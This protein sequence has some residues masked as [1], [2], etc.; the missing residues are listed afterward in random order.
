MAD[1]TL[2]DFACLAASPLLS[3]RSRIAREGISVSRCGIP[4]NPGVRIGT[5]Q[6]AV[7]VHDSEP[8]E[9]IC[10]S[11]RR[12]RI[13]RHRVSAGHF[14]ISAAGRAAHVSWTAAMCSLVIAMEDR[15]LK[16]T[17]ADAFGGAVPRVRS[18]AALRDPA[19]E[20]LVACLR[21]GMSDRSPSG[22]LCLE[23]VGMSLALRLFETYGDIARRPAP[24]R[25]GLGLSRERRIVDYIEAHLGE[26]IGL[27]A[28]AAEA[29]LSPH[30][31][32]KAFK[33]SFGK[34]PCRYMTERRVRKAK[35]M[36]LLSRLSVTE[37]AHA[38]GFASHSHF[39]DVFRKMTGTTPSQFRREGV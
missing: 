3:V 38:L 20:E 35:E 2:L 9:I 36:L 25:G 12:D 29:G 6:L 27:A 31:F 19:I 7:V 15:F 4:A 26:D 32:G 22:G 13:E 14:H 10:H 23:H 30:H 39:S 5:A 34:P 33:A 11:A 18:R 8:V 17:V 1:A 24:V 37:I 28:L 21:R 16:R